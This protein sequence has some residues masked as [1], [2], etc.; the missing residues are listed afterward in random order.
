MPRAQQLR[1]AIPATRNRAPV[2]RTGAKEVNGTASP[3]PAKENRE[4]DCLH[5]PQVYPSASHTD[6]LVW[7]ARRIRSK[8]Q[9]AVKERRGRPW[10]HANGR[11]A[12]S[13]LAAGE[14]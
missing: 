1:S 11:F 8:G 7:D 10:P 2:P 3:E 13:T 9:V 14:R 5:C 6:R 4:G 12:Q